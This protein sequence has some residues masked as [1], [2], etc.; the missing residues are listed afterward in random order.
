MIDISIVSEVYQQK[1]VGDHN[2][3]NI[4]ALCYLNNMKHIDIRGF[5]KMGVLQIDVFLIEHPN[6]KWM[7]T[8]N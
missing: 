6:L 2:S 7:I 1:K 8:S 3:N 4:H 5:P